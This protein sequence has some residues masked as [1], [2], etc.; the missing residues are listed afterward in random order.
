VIV[1]DQR[2]SVPP[3]EQ[4]RQQL[5]AAIGSGEVAAGAR[6]PTVRRFAEDLGIAP[7]T[8]ARTYRELEQADVLETRGRHGTFVTAG[9]AE[10]EARSAAAEFVARLRRLGVD[11]ATARGLVD[12]AFDASA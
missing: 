4:L 2:S 1:I 5:L 6:L 11:A 10:A 8:V 7:G 9:G 12:A 3:F